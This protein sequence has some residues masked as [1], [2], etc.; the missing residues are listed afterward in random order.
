MK[1][2]S[3]KY[4]KNSKN[5]FHKILHLKRK[6]VKKG[7]EMSANF[8]KIVEVTRIFRLCEKIEQQMYKNSKNNKFNRIIDLEREKG[9]EN[10]EKAAI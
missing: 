5:K 3:N 7:F 6:K 1:R 2:L 4:G 10:L 9:K 8:V